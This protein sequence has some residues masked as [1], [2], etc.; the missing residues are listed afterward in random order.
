MYRG[1]LRRWLLAVTGAASTTGFFASGGPAGAAS[2]RRILLINPNTNQ[3]TTDMMVRIAR[4]AAPN[5]IEIVGATAPHGPMM[6]VDPD[7]LAA[8][9][10][11]VVEIGVSVGKDVAGIIISAF[12]DP[13]F[14][15]LTRRVGIPVVGIAEASMRAASEKGR[16]FGVATTTP[17]LVP[18]INARAAEL[19]VAGSFTGVRLTS[20][21]PVQLAADPDRMTEALRQAVS[22]CVERD[23]AEA[24]VIG[25]GPL[26]N[27]ATA[28][29]PMF[30]IPVIAP[31]PAAVHRLMAILDRGSAR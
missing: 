14:A 20:G 16:R 5:D 11:Q 17:K 8:S 1:I 24:V 9:A 10:P 7:A 19:G 31:I 21:D 6:I 22:E 3:A 12:G 28:L 18:S 29:T 13:G 2:T 15:E 23:R 27:A 26:G 4:S 30:T 25:G